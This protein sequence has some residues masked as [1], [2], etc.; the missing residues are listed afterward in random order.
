M[1]GNEAE[2]STRD[3]EGGREQLVGGHALVGKDLEAN[4]TEHGAE[5]HGGEQVAQRK[6]L[7]GS[8]GV[9]RSKVIANE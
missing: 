6:K 2:G 7:R 5:H 1:D 8:F 3:E 9:Y 4:G